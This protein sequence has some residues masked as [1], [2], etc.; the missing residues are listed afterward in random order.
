MSQAPDRPASVPA[1]AVFVENAQEW[2]VGDFDEGGSP[3]GPHRLYRSDG[4]LAIT[5]NYENGELEGPYR[6]FH[7]NGELARECV[8]KQGKLDGKVQAFGS[9]DPTTEAL[10]GCCVPPG[11]FRLEARYEQG[12]HVF[13][14]FFNERGERILPD[15]SVY[16]P[17]PSHLPDEA[18]LDELSHRW[19]T[20]EYNERDEEGFYRFWAADG[21]LAEEKE[22]RSGKLHGK[23]R[24]YLPTGGLKEETHYEDDKRSGAYRRVLPGPGPYADSRIREERGTFSSELATGS[25]QFL[26]EH[27]NVIRTADFGAPHIEI[28]TSPAFERRALTAEGW[29]DVARDLAST[30]RTG[31][32]LLALAR[33]GAVSNDA[34]WL[35]DAMDELR[36]SLT[37]DYA[38]AIAA[39]AIETANG[40]L[41][42]LVNGLLR[43]G[44]PAA[45]F[46]SIAASCPH[47]T[48]ASLDFVNAAIL[49]A[50]DWD[51]C[52]VTRALIRVALGDPDGA[53]ADAGALSEAYAEQRQ[54]L[55]DYTRILFPSFDFW[56]ARARFDSLVADLPE[57][58]CQPLSKVR[59]AIQKCATRL[60]LVRG[61]VFELMG[62]KPAWELPDVSSLLPNGPVLLERRN[63]QVVEDEEQGPDAPSNQVDGAEEVVLDETLDLSRRDIASLMRL[64]R[65]DWCILTWLCWSAGLDRVGLPDRL[66]PPPNFGEA[67]GMAIERQWRAWDK[68]TTGGL[69]A[70]TK[71]VRPFEWEG[72]DVDFL[73]PVIA[74]LAALEYIDVRAA[75]FFL[76]DDRQESPWQDN[77]RCA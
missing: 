46:R 65:C 13:D 17:K 1:N 38:T 62:A 7:P 75:F 47:A 26:D 77:L 35:V 59:A 44:D 70:L 31:E 45:M 9:R 32:A 29:R 52:H 36:P 51:Q 73:S 14:R 68:F 43:G 69:M 56:P 2:R 41:D 50:P 11:A 71:G 3:V 16:P 23:V 57:E 28:E 74:E 12:T 53:R 25:W 66:T 20:F 55:L 24:T 21:T 37:A 67:V 4:A 49:L 22:T 76:C 8:Y 60:Q 5:C 34:R 33:A 48:R 54:F 58:P 61:A 27:G 10:R 72:L 63:F 18:K 42:A 40:K 64:A 19:Y 6:R 30:H 39:R 15:G